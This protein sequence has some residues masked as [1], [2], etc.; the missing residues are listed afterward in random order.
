M[1]FSFIFI[2]MVARTSANI[3]KS[4]P[5]ADCASISETYGD[6]LQKYASLD[7]DFVSRNEGL[8]STGAFQCFCQSELENNY[9]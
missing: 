5:K 4:F 2:Y 8:P 9:D 1:S 7:Y 6:Q 3:A